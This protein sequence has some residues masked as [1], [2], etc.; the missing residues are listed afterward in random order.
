MEP[1]A[2]IPFEAPLFPPLGT[3]GLETMSALAEVNQVVAG[4]LIEL[5][6][7]ALR[8]TLRAYSEVQTASLDAVRSTPA[9]ALP[10]RET[11]QELAQDPFAA[12]RRALLR[13]AEDTQRAGRLLE[14]SAQI[15]TRGAER[16]HATA[17][18]AGK[19]IRAAVT[20]CS[21]RIR[22]I[23]TQG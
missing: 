10:S 21:E 13:A 8:E 2:K 20:A 11:I 15:V 7:T 9:L 4:Q 6:S 22:D 19:D 3:R 16:W 1:S 18:R 14:T 5:S 17:E 12:Y 23:Y